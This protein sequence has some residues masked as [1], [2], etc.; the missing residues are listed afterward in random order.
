MHTKSNKSF[1]VGLPV[2]F[3]SDINVIHEALDVERKVRGVGTHQLLKLLA[4]LV[5]SDQCPGLGPDVQ[6]VLF[7]KLLTEVVDQDVVKV[8]AA[9]L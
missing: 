1:L 2:Q 4:L 9:K 6:L 5:Q 8:F 3:S 7:P